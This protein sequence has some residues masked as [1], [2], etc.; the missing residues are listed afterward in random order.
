M[1]VN[2]ANYEKLKDVMFELGFPGVF[3]RQIMIG[4]ETG[5]DQFRVGTRQTVTNPDGSETVNKYVVQNFQLDRE[6]DWTFLQ[7]P[8]RLE[9]TTN[10]E[11]KK[12]DFRIFGQRGFEKDKMLNIA[13]GRPVL[14]AYYKNNAKIERWFYDSGKV[15]EK[16][17]AVMQSVPK[18]K[19]NVPLELGLL[20]LGKVTQEQKE[21]AI[22]KLYAGERIPMPIIIDGKVETQFIE[23]SVSSGLKVTDKNNN[24]VVLKK[25]NYEV[26]DDLE[27]E[28][29]DLDTGQ[30][31]GEE[32]S[33]EEMMLDDETQA[34]NKGHQQEN[35]QQPEGGQQ[36][37]N[38]PRHEDAA[39]QQ[40]SGAPSADQEPEAA[41]QQK[42][43]GEVQQPVVAV[44]PV[45]QEAAPSKD[46]ANSV[47]N[48]N[49]LAAALD[50]Q[51]AAKAASILN[52]AGKQ[53]GQQVVKK[54]RNG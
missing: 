19:I 51:T 20:P 38:G 46:Q 35:G 37:D 32:L 29:M 10:G 7:G 22:H 39:Q 3:D 21:V 26:L 8:L 31:Q 9:Q 11:T 50:P 16:G 33:A 44:P 49:T 1:Q 6:R 48:K 4:L 43:A 34:Q 24:R 40:L 12:I 42:P 23:P 41:E 30:D 2:R 13:A 45:V 53:E 47:A 27:L 14:A 54:Q 15:D 28:Q 5:D 52:K 36:Q 17:V 18:E 25:E